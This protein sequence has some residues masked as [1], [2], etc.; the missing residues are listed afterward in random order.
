VGHYR[1]ERQVASSIG[2]LELSNYWHDMTNAVELRERHP[3]LFAKPAVVSEPLLPKSGS[4]GNK[5]T[6]RKQREKDSPKQA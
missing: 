5:T 2:Q 1:L 4:E 6:L 3:S